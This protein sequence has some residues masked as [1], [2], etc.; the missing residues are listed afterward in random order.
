MKVAAVIPT[1]NEQDTISALVGDLCAFCD[2]IIVADDS[3]D[4]TE[5]RASYAGA[6][7]FILRGGLSVAYGGA[8]KFI[9]SDWWVLHIDAGGSHDVMEA[10]D[11]VDIAAKLEYD[12]VIG[13]RFVPGARYLGNP[14]RRRMSQ[15]ASAMMNAVTP[16]DIG[17]WTSG[18]RVYS[19]TARAWIRGH[20][21]YAHGHAWQI[22]ALWWCLR[23]DCIVTEHAVTYTAGASHLDRERLREALRLWWLIAR[24]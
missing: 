17:D 1:R 24:S 3:T 13:S 10:I 20:P 23:N 19:P 2:R 9:P 8:D 12:V 11:L 22:E 16:Y 21:F 4:Q 14:T 18:L 7:T 15:L 6:E 5:R